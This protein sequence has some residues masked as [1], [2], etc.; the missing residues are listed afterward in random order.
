MSDKRRRS[1]RQKIEL[2]ELKKDPNSLLSW[3]L[4]DPTLRKLETYR[5]Y[6]A[7]YAVADISEAFDISC[8]YLYEMWGKFKTEGTSA[9]VD[10]RSGSSPRVRTTEREAKIIRAKALEPDRGDSDLGQKFG[11][12]R[13]TVY[14]LL[15]EHGIQ[16]LHRVLSGSEEAEGN[17]R[18]EDGREGDGREESGREVEEKKNIEIVPCEQ[19]LLL[20]LLNALDCSGSEK[21][22]SGLRL[23]GDGDVYSDDQM[24]LALILLSAWGVS[25]LSHIN[26]Q[27][28]ES[29]GVPLDSRRRPDEDT[30]DQ[31]LQ[32][33]I[34]QDETN[35]PT[36]VAER[37]G[38]IRSGGLI[39]QAQQASFRGWVEAG[40]TDG[41]VWYFDDH[42][43]EYTGQAGLGKTKHG[44][45]QTSV[46]AITRY[47][48]YNGLCSLSGY[49]SQ[50]VTYAEALRY[51][52]TKANDYLSSLDQINK[53][54]F[55]R[56]G[57]DAELLNWLEER[58]ISAITWVKKTAPN[59]KLMQAVPDE[60]F[61]ELDAKRS[62]GKEKEQEVVR[63]ADTTLDFPK[64]TAQRVVVLQTKTDQ[65]I[66]IYTTAPHPRHASL[67]NLRAMTTSGLMDAMRFKQRIENRF[68]VEKN[69]MD[70]DVIPTHKTYP[71]TLIEEYDLEQAQQTLSKA[72]QRVGKYTLDQENVQ[73]LYLDKRVDKHQLNLLK[74]RSLRLQKKTERQILTL[75]DQIKAVELDDNGQSFL[76]ST[77]QVLDVRKLTLLNLFKTHALVALKLLARRLRLDEAGPK[78]LR[79]SFL[80]FGDRVEFDHDNL[81]ATVFARPFP[82]AKMQLAYE[83]LCH[84]LDDV[85]ISLNRNG[86]SFRVKFR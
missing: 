36:T 45:K 5:L 3:G 7:G 73:Q 38:Q 18:E 27:P 56:A 19:A 47:T 74:K 6:E 37:Q 42:V 55:D 62:V 81:I 21:A 82:R 65:Q 51:L 23:K 67:D 78:R 13:S 76:T 25:R 50:S 79:R 53:L 85:P 14:H 31:Y 60:E 12:H 68:K 16:D 43:I 11:M 52:V 29:W 57:W 59:V 10:K 48:L 54:S 40:L 1:Q 86:R 46:K 75:S 70:C 69:E 2:D 63:L 84:E 30:F 32:A 17:G 80:A 22:L 39:D 35:S 83:A 8:G 33:V 4:E 20:T 26:D 28:K 24:H 49:F 58:Q 41:E 15:K 61:V 72:K 44:T 71:T 77:T 66:G 9:L 34:E 64:L